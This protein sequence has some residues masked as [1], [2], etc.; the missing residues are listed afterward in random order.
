MKRVSLFLAVKSRI[1]ATMKRPSQFTLTITKVVVQ[2]PTITLA[3][4]AITIHPT[5][6]IIAT[7]QTDMAV[8]VAIEIMEM[9]VVLSSA[10]LTFLP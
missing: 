2:T 3:A 7:H 8:E 5:T 4:T 6:M 10:V 1:S 9:M